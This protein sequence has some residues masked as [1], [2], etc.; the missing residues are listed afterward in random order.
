MGAKT[1]FIGLDGWGPDLIQEGIDTGALPN[2]ARLLARLKRVR[3]DNEPGFGDGVYWTSAATGVDTA[4]HGIYFI[5]QFNPDT[6]EFD[7]VDEAADIPVPAF[8]QEADEAGR[9]VC[10]I[11]WPHAP[12]RQM[13]NGVHVDNWIH[14]D[15]PIRLRTSPDHVARKLV[16]EYGTDPFLPGLHAHPVETAEK[17]RW[18]TE[19]G[20][21]R[22]ATKGRFCADQLGESDWDFFGVVFSEP[23][24]LGH[25]A[26]H[27]IEPDHPYYDADIAA[28][29]GNPLTAVTAAT[30]KVIGE[31]LA[32]AGA[33]TE[34]M[35]MAGLGM[36]RL[37]T[38]NHVFDKVVERLDCGLEQEEAPVAQARKAYRSAIPLPVRKALRPVRRLLAGKSP[39]KPP[40]A[41][42]RF[43]TLLHVDNAGC[44][45]INLKGR[46]RYGIVE[47]EDYDALL[48]EIAADCMD[49]R[50]ADTG[51]PIVESVLKVREHFDGPML[52][53]LPDLVVNWRRDRSLRQI[54]SPK[55]G[56]IVLPRR[57]V[58]TGDHILHGDLWAPEPRLRA[59]NIGQECLPADVT[60]AIN[61]AL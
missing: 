25:N 13:K 18:L 56:E 50:D 28:A 3:V 47:P 29:A 51:E 42:R 52:D 12:F 45:R 54:V 23:H 20:C 9:S 34:V 39:D 26:F 43:F 10:V 36:R 41:D 53:K 31:M 60:R 17:A 14:H 27:I 24:D 58:R 40:L 8:W 37:V 5:L 2:L 19:K 48:D 4:G 21:E 46:E 61:V 33:D 35:V 7:W 30:D 59:A 55:I 16:E 22:I 57:E 11:D 44:I 49:I 15:T 6:Y 32:Q 1:L 38:I